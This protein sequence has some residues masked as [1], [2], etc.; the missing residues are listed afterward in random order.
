[1][2]HGS[3]FSIGCFLADCLLCVLGQR[4][5][6][7][8]FSSCDGRDVLAR[9]RRRSSRRMNAP[10]R[11][12]R[13]G[14]P[15]SCWLVGRQLG[16]L[17]RRACFAFGSRLS[18]VTV[19]WV[20]ARQSAPAAPEA[21]LNANAARTPIVTPASSVTARHVAREQCRSSAEPV[22]QDGVVT[23]QATPPTERTGLGGLA[24][25]GKQTVG[26]AAD[27]AQQTASQVVEQVQGTAGRVI[28]QVQETSG[29]VVDQIQ[30]QA[31]RA[32]SFLQR[33]L[34]ENPILVG[35]F[36]VAVGGVL[37]ATVPVTP[38]EDQL[39]GEARDH[40]I[41]TAKELTQDT[42]HKVGRDVDEAQSA[43]KEEAQHQ[44]LV[45]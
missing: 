20:V 29:E 28:D 24:D 33:Q 6:E 7:S 40:V 31:S 17:L 1:M 25:D 39:M 13:G 21:V 26:R 19:V 15:L 3:A 41:G 38:R 32:Q 2:R 12:G 9:R 22:L 27:Q 11:G 14:A 43:A 16:V 23:S 18:R 36:A 10:E 5:G 34:E 42:M 8:A 30:T 45:P 37:A 35:A 44:S 4:N